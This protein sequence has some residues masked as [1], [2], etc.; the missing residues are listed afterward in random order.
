MSSGLIRHPTAPRVG[1][2]NP[3]LSISFIRTHPERRGVLVKKKRKTTKVSRNEEIWHALG[4]RNEMDEPAGVSGKRVSFSSK[5]E[6][7]GACA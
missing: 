4:H 5:Y 2:S 6:P 7:S 3:G 1:G